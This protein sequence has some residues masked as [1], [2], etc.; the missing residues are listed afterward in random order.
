MH[1]MR[2]DTYS[3]GSHCASFAVEAVISGDGYRIG[4]DHWTWVWAVQTRQAR[5]LEHCFGSM[6][7]EAGSRARRERR[8]D[9]LRNPAALTSIQEFE[10]WV[11][12]KCCIHWSLSP[13]HNLTRIM[14]LGVSHGSHWLFSSAPSGASYAPLIVS[15]L[16]KIY[17]Y[18]QL[19]SDSYTRFCHHTMSPSDAFCTANPRNTTLSLRAWMAGIQL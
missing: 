3:K 14:L 15:S 1:L 18:H 19:G 8:I 17:H 9:Q 5:E 7:G 6:N 11:G 13:S 10:R 2:V 4:S 16:T 12:E